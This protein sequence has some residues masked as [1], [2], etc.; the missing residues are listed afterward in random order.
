MFDFGISPMY[1]LD[2]DGKL[3]EMQ[4]LCSKSGTMSMNLL[5][6][7][8]SELATQQQL[9]NDHPRLPAYLRVKQGF[10]VTICKR[11]CLD[12]SAIQIACQPPQAATGL[13]AGLIVDSISW[14]ATILC[15]HAC[16]IEL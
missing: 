6:A 9:I 4:L 10:N 1:S 8:I 7:F 11:I 16:V 15:V 3:C 13:R 14:Q 2:N 12:T 5:H